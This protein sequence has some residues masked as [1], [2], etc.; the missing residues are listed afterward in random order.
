LQEAPLV[1]AARR[2]ALPGRRAAGG[3]AA[4]PA[5][6]PARRPRG[7]APELE[8]AP[9]RLRAALEAPL[10]AL[11]NL[12]AAPPSAH[13]R[14]RLLGLP[15]EGSA[16]V[17]GS[18]PWLRGILRRR[19]EALYAEFRSV[20]GSFRLVSVGGQ[21]GLAPD[22]AGE[23]AEVWV[24]RALVLNAP[25]C[26]LAAAVSQT[27]VPEPL[28]GAPATRRRH[29]LHLRA[30]RSFVP[31]AMAP[32]VIVLRDPL[33]PPEG[34][35]ALGL[36]RFPA[37]D[38]AHQVDLVVSAVLDAAEPDLPAREA[39]MQ[40]AVAALLP[41]AEESLRRVPDAAP[42]W[43][44]DAPLCDPPAGAGW[45]GEVELRLPSRQPLYQLERAGL[46]GLGLEGE[47][48]L[49]WR[50]GDAIAADLE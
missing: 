22:E 21:P 4:G 50:A 9:A 23:S 25:R 20:P 17:R 44:D 34:T 19:L 2:H 39:E 41:F 27:P 1:R 40:A 14:A 47:I 5:A 37:A 7:P 10:R 8:A 36:R 28:E 48:L 49:G 16:S 3:E 42:R 46:A 13:A 15:L 12:G 33:Q 38:D 31:E 11:S 43:D 45:P 26:A 24:G 6:R 18:D 30:P 29:A 32:R 35:N